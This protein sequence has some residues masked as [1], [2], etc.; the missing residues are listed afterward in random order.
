M[1]KGRLRSGPPCIRLLQGPVLEV[2]PE[3]VNVGSVRQTKRTENF[4][5]RHVGKLAPALFG[6]MGDWDLCL[7]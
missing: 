7:K 5:Q 1:G 4:R 3:P 6:E 2:A